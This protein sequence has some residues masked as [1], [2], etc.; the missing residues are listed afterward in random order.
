MKLEVTRDV[1]SDLWPLYSTGEASM[2][3]RN[4]VDTFLSEDAS[5]A[6]T[7]QESQKL[8][9]AMPSLRLSPDAERRLLD[10]A[11]QRARIKLL[12]IGGTIALAGLVLLVALGG[13]LW[14]VARGF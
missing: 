14:V 4:L 5:F 13:A 6:A 10:Q 9:G 8:P 3:S 2:D 7:L 12:L 1:V 11:R